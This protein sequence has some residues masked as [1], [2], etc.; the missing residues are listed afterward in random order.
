[1]W[2]EFFRTRVGLMGTDSPP[3]SPSDSV[4][5]DASVDAGFPDLAMPSM[6]VH[7]EVEA[8]VEC[9]PSL[10]PIGPSAFLV[11]PAVLEEQEV[12][13][14]LQGLSAALQSAAMALDDPSD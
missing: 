11:E 8:A 3:E 12:Q 4:D 10:A 7:G 14:L 6:V 2:P 9:D 13:A 5:R 1:M